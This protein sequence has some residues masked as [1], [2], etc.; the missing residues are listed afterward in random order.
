MLLPSNKQ[1]FSILQDFYKANLKKKIFWKRK[2]NVSELLKPQ[3]FE[4]SR[5][6]Y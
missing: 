1:V 3:A 6:N 5:L 2:P 4:N